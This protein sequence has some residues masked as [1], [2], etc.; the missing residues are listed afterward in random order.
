MESFQVRNPF[1]LLRLFTL[2]LFVSFLF[3]AQT[4]FAA[5]TPQ[6]SGSLV[7]LG[8][9]TYPRATVLHDGTLLAGYT[10]FDGATHILRIVHSSDGGVTWNQRGEVARGANDLDNIY[11]LQLPSG[12]VLA[13]FRN[14][15]N[16]RAYFRI[17]VCYSDDVG[18][19]WAFLSTPAENP[20]T[21]NGLWEPFFRLSNSGVLQLYYSRE[22]AE[23]DQDSLL[24]TST[25]GGVTWSAP[26]T[27]SGSGVTA[28]DG[29]VGVVNAGGNR[30]VAVFETTQGVN[31]QFVV[32]AITSNDDGLTWSS[33]R[34]RVYTPTARNAGAPQ[35]VNVGGTLVVSF[36]TDE[37]TS[38]AHVW[39]AQAAAKVVTSVDG[40]AKW[41]NKV[42]VGPTASLWP[43]MVGLSGSTFLALFE[44]QGA[45]AQRVVLV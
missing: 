5:G 22:N 11:V 31:G 9:G 4:A 29:M 45:Q 21:V 13:A 43:G 40:G 12:R 36:M 23:N 41:G 28:R 17:T 1:V 25:N 33:A 26:T 15:D 34:T 6:L 2:S 37:D 44:H 8:A 20:G 32:D 35:I 19:N 18:A 3:N 24:R 27:I 7:S 14:H 42:T 16:N 38:S 39:P 10:A 30:L